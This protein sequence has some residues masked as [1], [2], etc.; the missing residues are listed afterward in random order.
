M[1]ISSHELGILRK[2]KVTVRDTFSYSQKQRKLCSVQIT[3]QVHPLL[4]LLNPR[5]NDFDWSVDNVVLP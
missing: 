1:R 4:T 2:H 5:K 3:P